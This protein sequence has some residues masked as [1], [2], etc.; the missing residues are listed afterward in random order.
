MGAMKKRASHG[1]ESR[2]PWSFRPQGYDAKSIEDG[3]VS[4]LTGCENDGVF[5][6]TR[7]AAL[8]RDHPEWLPADRAR[9]VEGVHGVQRWKR[10][11]DHLDGADGSSLPEELRCRHRFHTFEKWVKGGFQIPGQC[12]EGVRHSLPDWIEESGLRDHP[13]AWPLLMSHLNTAPQVDLRANRL[14]VTLGELLEALAL[15]AVVASALE[16]FPDALCLEGFADVWKT[17]A[18]QGGLFEVQDRHSQQISRFLEVE[19]GHAV[20]DA[21]AGNGGKTLHLSALMENRGR[22][23]AMDTAEHKL[24]ALR[25][26][27][28]KAGCGNLELRPI[29][30]PLSIKRLRDR[31]DRLLLDVPCSG[32]GTLRRNPALRWQGQEGL[33]LLRGQQAEILDRYSRMVRKGGCLVYATCSFLRSENEDQVEAFLMRHAS[34]WSWEATFQ[35]C[36]SQ[37]QGDY[38]FAARLRR[39]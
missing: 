22:L 37:M 11:L 31:A 20:I 32:L 38:L 36:A 35:P 13:E 24:K 6:S 7:L 9:V 26:R 2:N 34:S 15:E 28:R 8:F 27:A 18:F 12:P 39:T 3:I 19:P 17:R 29:E 30:G 1:G 25:L 23:I 14:R 4:V 5:A 33:T 10:L 16:G 21:C